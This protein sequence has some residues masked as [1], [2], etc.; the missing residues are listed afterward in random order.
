M[1]KF[2]EEELSMLSETERAALLDEDDQDGACWNTRLLLSQ[3]AM[4]L[5]RWWSRS[6]LHPAAWPGYRRF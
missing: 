5:K 6:L 1:E 2:T 4:A 3:E